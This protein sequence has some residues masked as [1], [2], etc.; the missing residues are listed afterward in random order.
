MARVLTR[1][2]WN[3]PAS[4]SGRLRAAGQGILLSS[5]LLALTAPSAVCGEPT[6]LDRLQRSTERCRQLEYEVIAACSYAGSGRIWKVERTRLVC[7][8]ERAHKCSWA[9]TVDSSRE[10]MP[11]RPLGEEWWAELAARHLT[12]VSAPTLEYFDGRRHT[13]FQYAAKGDGHIWSGLRHLDCK[14]FLYFP[15]FL[16]GTYYVAYT[17]L[18]ARLTSDQVAALRTPWGQDALIIVNPAYPEEPIVALMDP[19]HRH[20]PSEMFLLQGVDLAATKHRIAAAQGVNQLRA[21][22][23]ARWHYRVLAWAKPHD[24]P[25][26][27]RV[28][29]ERVQGVLVDRATERREAVDTTYYLV[30]ASKAPSDLEWSVLPPELSGREVLVTDLLLRSRQR[31]LPDGSVKVSAVVDVSE[32]EP[33]EE[34]AVPRALAD[35]GPRLASA[36]R[37]AAIGLLVGL[38]LLLLQRVPTLRRAGTSRSGGTSV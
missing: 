20:L 13:S 9:R 14:A 11:Q 2:P 24:A 34:S 30:R 37:W 15:N 38:V 25:V 7:V 12:D 29:R 27:P 3:D 22:M 31:Y 35:R 21:T 4:R 19:R 17:P 1:F 6:D 28:C 10:C 18:H 8:R 23:K 33:R 5:I 26:L 16:R 36:V 32:I